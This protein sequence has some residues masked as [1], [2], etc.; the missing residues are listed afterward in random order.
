MTVAMRVVVKVKVD[1]LK[2]KGTNILGMESKSPSPFQSLS[3]SLAQAIKLVSDSK[4][5]V[6]RLQAVNY[7]AFE[8][9]VMSK[10]ATLNSLSEDHWDNW[11]NICHNPNMTWSLASRLIAAGYSN[12]LHWSDLSIHKNISFDVIKAH[13]QYHWS[14]SMVTRNPNITAAIIRDN[15]NWGWQLS[16]IPNSN[17]TWQMLWLLRALDDQATAKQATNQPTNQLLNSQSLKLNINWLSRHH[18]ITLDMILSRRDVAWNWYYASRNPNI[19]FS[20]IKAHPELHWRSD[21]VSCNPSIT[22]DDVNNNPEY[23]W[24]W[25]CLSSNENISWSTLEK[26]LQSLPASTTKEELSN[27]FIWADVSNKP[28]VTWQVVQRCPHY[29]WSKMGL[30]CNPNIPWQIVKDNPDYGWLT[31]GG[32]L[33]SLAS[34]PN[35]SL[36]QLREHCQANSISQNVIFSTA[37]N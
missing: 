36:E 7:R 28:S 16:G 3:P 18:N 34:N 19:T 33:H 31:V 9:Y 24:D 10:L 11:R 37:I 27:L 22:D 12:Q 25:T 23:P 35:I 29:P 17:L 5:R 32:Y 30:A 20:L 13:P 26:K 6:R 4:R 8:S 2:Q 21:S 14:K 15:P 1:C